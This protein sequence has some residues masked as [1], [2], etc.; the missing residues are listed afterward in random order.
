MKELKNESKKER[1]KER[2][3]KTEQRKKSKWE[4]ILSLQMASG[5]L[6]EYRSRMQL[7][8]SFPTGQKMYLRE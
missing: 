4:T 5:D 2:K 1:K 8:V 6:F 3:K 7:F